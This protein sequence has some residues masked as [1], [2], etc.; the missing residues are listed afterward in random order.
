MD[1]SAIIAAGG[2]GRRLGS[3]TP[4]QLLEIGGRSMLEH[5]VAAFLTHPRVS[6]VIVVVPAAGIAPEALRVTG[7]GLRIAT[8]GARR[9]DSVAAALTT[10]AWQPRSCWSTTRRGPSSRRR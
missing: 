7:E 8:G 3:D 2:A 6:E 10:L 9:Q 1:V 5:S 4:K